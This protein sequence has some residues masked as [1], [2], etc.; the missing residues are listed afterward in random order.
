[1]RTIIV[2]VFLFLQVH[3]ACQKS[4]DGDFIFKANLFLEKVNII[5]VKGFE[6]KNQDLLLFFNKNIILK[7]DPLQSI[8]F[9]DN[10]YFLSLS[11]KN[12][13]KYN[14]TIIKTD[15]SFFLFIEND[16]V[17]YVLAINKYSGKSYR[18]KGFSGNDFFNLFLDLNRQ[19]EKLGQRKISIDSFLKWYK[20]NS[21]D[22]KCLYKAFFPSNVSPCS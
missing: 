17:D 22:L 21:V 19:F 3:G 1:M 2:I 13:V 6:Q 18:L 14:D 9:S 10:Y 12:G 15:S 7:L 20:I 4:I 16:C 5:N 11:L 8:G